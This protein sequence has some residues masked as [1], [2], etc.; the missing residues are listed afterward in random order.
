MFDPKLKPLWQEVTFWLLSLISLPGIIALY[1]GAWD[2]IGQGTFSQ[3]DFTL[4]A[5]ALPVVAYLLTRQYPRGKAAEA[6]GWMLAAQQSTQAMVAPLESNPD[7]TGK[8][9]PKDSVP[10]SIDDDEVVYDYG[11][12]S[13]TTSTTDHPDDYAGEGA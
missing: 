8:L 7:M 10:D 2:A 12:D 6:S 13:P 5:F 9:D 1:K 3:D 11:S 4:S